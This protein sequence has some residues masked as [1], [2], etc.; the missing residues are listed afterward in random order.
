MFTPEQ[1]FTRNLDY[2]HYAVAH[3]TINSLF[4]A[5]AKLRQL[6]TDNNNLLHQINR[7]RK[8]NTTFPMRAWMTSHPFT[9]KMG[10][11]LRC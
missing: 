10:H 5:S 8:L 2:L 6:L 9:A 3:P 11:L 4:E 1:L 7:V